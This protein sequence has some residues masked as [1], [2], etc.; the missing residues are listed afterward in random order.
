[1]D[2]DIFIPTTMNYWAVLVAAVAYF[3]LGALWYSAPLFGRT[4]LNGV[5]KTEAQVKADF[6]PMNLV[7]TFIMNWLAAYGVARIFVWMRGEDVVD[8]IKIG[9]LTGVCFALATVMMHDVMEK[10]RCSL[11]IINGL[12]SVVGLIFVGIVIGLWQ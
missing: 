3:V 9:L 11:T 4:W 5:G 7:W 12:Y 8:G 2:V 1:M 6:S 10:R